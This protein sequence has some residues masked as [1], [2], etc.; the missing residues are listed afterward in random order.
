MQ[1]TYSLFDPSGNTTILVET[2]V[3]V[4]DQ[5][6]VAS[7]LMKAEPSA[8]QVGFVSAPAQHSDHRSGHHQSVHQSHR[9]SSRH[10]GRAMKK[11]KGHRHELHKKGRHI[12]KNPEIY[13]DRDW[14]ELWNGCHVRISLDRISILT[15]SGDR[16][17]WAD[18]V[19]L[20]PSGLY[21][22]DQE[23]LQYFTAGICIHVLNGRVSEIDLFTVYQTP[24][25]LYI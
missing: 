3:P 24:E 14:Q 13:C 15:Q 18:E 9:H 6:A 19:I 20:L 22:I 2:P 21:V 1:I 7:A 23:I 5:P 11:D 12:R 16:L 4:E 25:V 17:I 8:E 10:S